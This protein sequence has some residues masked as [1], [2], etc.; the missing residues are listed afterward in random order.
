MDDGLVAW[1]CQAG[2]QVGGTPVVGSRQRGECGGWGVEQPGSLA[3]GIEPPGWLIRIFS[4]ENGLGM[5]YWAITER[6]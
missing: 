6:Q 3:V 2:E 5:M 4:T 1:R